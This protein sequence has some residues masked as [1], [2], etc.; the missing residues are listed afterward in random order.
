MNRV[1]SVCALCASLLF[2]LPAQ[3]ETKVYRDAEQAFLERT[4]LRAAD[5]KCGYFTELERTALT[6]GQLQA[7]GALLRAGVD[8]NAIESAASEVERFANMQDCGSEDFMTAA[9]Y[10]KDSFSAFIG[11]MVMDFTGA[12]SIWKASRS[13]WDTW[14]IVQDRTT[15]SF[16]YQFGLLAPNIDDPD[17]FPASFSRPLDNP[18]VEKPFD[19]AL[20]LHLDEGQKLPASARILIRDPAKSIEPW[21]GNIFTNKPGPPPRALTSAH[22][23]SARVM[24][25]DEDAGTRTARFRFSDSATQALM[26]L[27]PRERVEILVL[28]DAREKDQR[29]TSLT[30]EVGDFTAAYLFTKL[31][32]L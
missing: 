10:L 21:L 23:P 8:I 18:L 22:W 2:V 24:M 31:P 14:R 4:S 25:E 1:S 12:E 29:P 16:V 28:P 13:R 3:A 5:E 11:T 19:L 27:D 32:P 6:A 26:E 17:A 20:D 30:I 15:D 9:G 7:R